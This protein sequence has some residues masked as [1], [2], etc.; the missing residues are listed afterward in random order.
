MQ[1]RDLYAKLLGLEP[2]WEVVDVDIS[3]EDHAVQVFVA[4]RAGA[5]TPCPACRK[6]CPRH[7]TRTRSWRHLDTMQYK[8]MLV[9]EIPRIDCPTHGTRQVKVPWA[10][11]RSRYT[12]LFECLVIEWLQHGSIKAVAELLAMSWDQVAGI[13]ARRWTGASP[14]G[15]CRF[16]RWWGSMRPHSRSDMST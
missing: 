11:P 8:T 9:A 7:D 15:S 12:A 14:A 2:P 6:R 13:M 16:P 3:M 1:D 10:G 4:L 5:P